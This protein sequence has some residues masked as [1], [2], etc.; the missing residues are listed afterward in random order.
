MYLKY[1]KTNTPFI[2]FDN[3]A[4][5][6]FSTI[7]KDKE[8]GYK[9]LVF[10]HTETSAVCVSSSRAKKKRYASVVE[11]ISFPTT[12]KFKKI[13]NDAKKVLTPITLSY[14]KKTFGKLTVDDYFPEK[15]L[16][17]LDEVL[18]FVDKTDEIDD[19][20][21]ANESFDDD[22]KS[23]KKKLKKANGKPLKIKI[24]P[25]IKFGKGK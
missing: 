5:L 7:T 3:G 11:N 19:D 23:S 24:K 20:P 14:L 25:K 9:F 13:P 4:K 21:T 6:I 15:N 2:E 1:S 22:I 18:S 10:S 8:K 16:D 12:M 17:K